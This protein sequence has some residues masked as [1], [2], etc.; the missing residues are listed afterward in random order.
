[1]MSKYSDINF[2]FGN[3]AP[4]I[5]LKFEKEIIT[6]D[7]DTFLRHYHFS[8]FKRGR[9][10]LKRLLKKILTKINNSSV[11]NNI[12]FKKIQVK[13]IQIRIEYI[14]ENAISIIRKSLISTQSNRRIKNIEN[15][16]QLIEQD[17]D[18]G[19]PLYIQ[20]ECLSEIA[21]DVG[22]GTPI[23]VDGS[24]RLMAN[25]LNKKQS[26][27]IWLITLKEGKQ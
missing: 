26:Y 22:Y 12:F 17:I 13:L 20:R 21:T 18:L 1:M 16:E 10:F 2:S 23:Q 25:I 11:I 3:K 24:R 7:I 14:N 4:I 9:F 19:F 15:F 27:R 6:E 8:K 5:T